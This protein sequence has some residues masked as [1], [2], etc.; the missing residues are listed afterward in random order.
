MTLGA[1]IIG[2]A[3][4]KINKK[5]V[6]SKNTNRTKLLKIHPDNLHEPIKTKKGNNFQGNVIDLIK[7]KP[8]YHWT[9]KCPKNSSNW[10]DIYSTGHVVS[11]FRN[12]KGHLRHSIHIN[13]I[14]ISLL[15]KYSSWHT[16]EE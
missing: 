2:F 12:N 8:Y 6:C 10:F 16:A 15:W 3:G 14:K 7:T 1:F 13:G 4:E 9:V 11:S 5:V